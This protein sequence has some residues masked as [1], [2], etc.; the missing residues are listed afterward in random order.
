MS[1]HEE[2]LL[3]LPVKKVFALQVRE[4]GT[5][6]LVRILAFGEDEDVPETH[7]PPLPDV[8]EVNAA[9]YRRLSSDAANTH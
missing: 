6:L 1:D 2:K 7:T 5:T 8:I 3:T 9:P 4:H